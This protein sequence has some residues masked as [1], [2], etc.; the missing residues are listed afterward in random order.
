MDCIDCH[1]RAAHGMQTAEEALSRSMEE[2]VI[3]PDLPFVHKEGLVL[4]NESY[5]SEADAR[6][7][8]PAGLVAFYQKQYPQVM[9]QKAALVKA[10]GEGLVQIYSHN[11]FPEMKVTWG[12]IRTTLGT[13]GRDTILSGLLSL[14]RW[15]PLDLRCEG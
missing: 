10:A 11:V 13:T 4:L 15:G 6:E 5:T 9:Q 2:N 1:N 14:P 12:R 8:I 7:K 3:S